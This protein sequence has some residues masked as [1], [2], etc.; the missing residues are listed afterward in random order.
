MCK[1]SKTYKNIYNCHFIP[2]TV[3]SCQ[4]LYHRYSALISCYPYFIQQL[5]VD[6]HYNILHV[7]ARWPGSASD[8]YIFNCSEVRDFGDRGLFGEHFIVAD[9][10]YVFINFFS[11]HFIL[12]NI[13]IFF[14]SVFMY[15]KIFLFFI[16]LGSVCG[17]TAS[18]QYLGL[19]LT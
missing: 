1:F 9:A 5:I 13:L 2:S 4:H 15:T 10:G 3:T 7:D 14:S 16:S 18:L 12:I 11:S 6:A 19:V 8:A 17:L